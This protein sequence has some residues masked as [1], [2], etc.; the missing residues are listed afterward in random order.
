MA[1]GHRRRTGLGIA[2]HQNTAE[3]WSRR[4]AEGYDLVT[5]MEL[6]EH[7]PDPASVIRACAVMVNPGGHLVCATLNRNVKSYLFA[8]WGAEYILGLLPAKTHDWR[9]FVTPG[10]LIR[11]AEGQGMTTGRQSGLAYNPFTRRYRLSGDLSVNY[12]LHFRK[13]L[14]A[15]GARHVWD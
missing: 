4:N 9:K 13:P 8:I 10:E 15:K 6:L 1:D 3:Q 7:V 14:G 11:L 2:Y 12:L 5:C